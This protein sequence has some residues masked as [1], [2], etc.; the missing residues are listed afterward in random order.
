M[1]IPDKKLSG[2]MHEREVK[3]CKNLFF[4]LHS[5]FFIFPSVRFRSAK[6]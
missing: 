3:I 2:K 5:S 4:T 1:K 6:G